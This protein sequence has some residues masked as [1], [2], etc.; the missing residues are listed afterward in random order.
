MKKLLFYFFLPIILLLN[1]CAQKT[2]SIIPLQNRSYDGIVSGILKKD[3]GEPLIIKGIEEYTKGIKFND[4][5][6]EII[7]TQYV[8]VYDVNIKSGEVLYFGGVDKTNGRNYFYSKKTKIITNT[9][10]KQGVAIDFKNNKIYLFNQFAPFVYEKAF[11]LDYIECEYVNN[12][13]N[14]CFKQELV[15][16]GKSSNIIKIIYRE[17]SN[18][19]ARPAF[20]Q[21]LNYDLNDGNIISFKGCKIEVIEAKNTGIEYKILST[22]AD[23]Y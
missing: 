11:E 8:Y 12:D 19:L 23:K 16:N 21:E 4:N 10:I 3:L 20:T 9:E 7:K 22:F 5:I 17:F 2:I 6:N 1:S 18:D 13:C 14:N 15:Y